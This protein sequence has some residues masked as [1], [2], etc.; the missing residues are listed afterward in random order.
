MEAEAE[1]E[2]RP[3][4]A[5]TATA[6]SVASM[7]IGLGTAVPSLLEAEAAPVVEGGAV[8]EEATTTTT[9]GATAAMR[10]TIWSRIAPIRQLEAVT[11]E[12]CRINK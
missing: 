8:D 3:H 12:E 5:L 4:H 6:L 9:G 7:A 11:Q 10:L 2:V 1:A